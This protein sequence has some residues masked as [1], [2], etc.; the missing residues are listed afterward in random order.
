[1]Y[2]TTLEKFIPAN[3]F[4]KIFEEA[5]RD[6][7]VKF[8]DLPQIGSWNFKGTLGQVIVL[9]KDFLLIT[10]WCGKWSHLY[11]V[12]INAKEFHELTCRLCDKDQTEF[13]M[14]GTA[15]VKYADSTFKFINVQYGIEKV[16][17]EYMKHLLRV[18]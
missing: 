1:M 9:G 17:K 10:H 2:R 8:L 12:D 14:D 15:Y 11:H 3:Y 18:I 7:S 13:A 4:Q 16:E 6:L 5:K